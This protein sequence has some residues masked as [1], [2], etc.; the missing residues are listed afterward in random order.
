MA[1]ENKGKRIEG[2]KVK[3]SEAKAKGKARESNPYER[4]NMRDA[5]FDGF[6]GGCEETAEA[7]E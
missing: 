3:G 5:W 7:A 2:A 6:D 4:P 1:S